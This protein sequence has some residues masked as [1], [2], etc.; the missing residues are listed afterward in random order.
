[1]RWLI[2]LLIGVTVV[3][4]A[5]GTTPPQGGQSQLRRATHHAIWDSINQANEARSVQGH[6]LAGGGVS[7]AAPTPGLAT[8]PDRSVTATNTV[9]DIAASTPTGSR[10]NPLNVA[11][12]EGVTARNVPG[13]VGGRDYSAHAF[14][15]M[16]GQGI[17]PTV[18]EN[19]ITPANALVGKV[20]GTT[21]YYDPVNNITVITNTT[22]GRVVTVDYGKIRQ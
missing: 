1:M 18:V 10:G 14:D 21:A 11:T 2:A 13:S 22:S 7:S 3:L 4:V 16:Q 9:D 8:T 12:P 17:T 5:V 15:R 20:P 6:R 19:T